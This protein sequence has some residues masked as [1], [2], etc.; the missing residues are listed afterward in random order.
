MSTHTESPD[1]VGTGTGQRS[2]VKIVA[3]SLVGTAVEWYDFFLFGSAAALVFGEVF[4]GQIGGTEGHAV[5]LHDLRPRLR[6]PPAR[7]CRLR[8]LR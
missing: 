2:I 1:Q 4:F 6:R 3:A 8:P 5:R 7:R